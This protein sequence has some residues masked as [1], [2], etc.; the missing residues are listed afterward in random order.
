MRSYSSQYPLKAPILVGELALRVAMTEGYRKAMGS[1]DMREF[2]LKSFD[3]TNIY[4]T[5]WDDV[6]APKGVIQLLHGM[7]EYAGRYDEFAR[8]LNTRGYIVF[9]DDHRAH[10][11]T[12]KDENRGRHK[13]NIFKKTLQDALYFREWLSREYDLPI[14]IAGHSYGSFL[15]QAF[16]QAGTDVK[17]IALIGSG[18]MRGLFNFGKIMIAPIYLVARNWRPRIVNWCSDNMYH[19]DGDEGKWQWVNSLKERREEMFKDKY[20]HQSMS[21]GFDFH[22]MAETSKLYSKKALARLNPATAIGIFS[23]GDDTV[24]EK[25]KGVKRLYD[26]Y[27]SVG[28]NCDLHIYEGARHE[29]IYDHSGKRVQSDIADFFDKFI[30]Y[31]QATIDELV[32]R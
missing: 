28:I 19:F 8:Y 16:A 27:K 13:G 21:V 23:G 5:I 22:M 10:G 12:E 20:L 14:F 11:R 17:A 2:Y 32:R 4:V 26:M 6:P 29:V 30:V 1:V 24:G 3:N 25:G 31:E 9:A 15:C 7:S 18:H